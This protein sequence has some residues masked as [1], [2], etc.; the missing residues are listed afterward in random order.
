[1][2]FLVGVIVRGNE[3]VVRFIVAAAPAIG[4]EVR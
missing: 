1:M 3:G 2:T 4:D